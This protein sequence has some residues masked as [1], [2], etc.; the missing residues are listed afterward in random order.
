ME[1]NL[2]ECHRKFLDSYIAK[3]KLSLKSLSLRSNKVV[4][5]STLSRVVKK[6]RSG[7]YEKAFNISIESWV[8]FVGNL[9]LTKEEA[10]QAILLRTKDTVSLFESTLLSCANKLFEKVHSGISDGEVS[11]DSVSSEAL[12]L[13]DTYDKLPKRFQQSIANEAFK[14][15]GYLNDINPAYS[16]TLKQNKKIM[17]RI[18]N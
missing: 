11:E 15:I 9:S 7:E 14:V 2:H 3:H 5:A 12:Y 6:D 17:K 13:A 10:L 4:S 18:I 16:Q 1:L 8:E